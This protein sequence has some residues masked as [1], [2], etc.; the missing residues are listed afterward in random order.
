MIRGIAALA[1]GFG[2]LLAIGCGSNEEPVAE[3]TVEPSAVELAYPQ[4]LD[5]DLHW[6][7]LEALEAAE[8][9]VYVFVHLLDEP[10][11]VARTF[12]HGLGFAWSE[13]AEEKT[14]VR[15]YQSALAPPLRP[16]EYDLT[17]GL[18][19][20]TGRRWPLAT[21]GEEVDGR[22]YAV[23]TVT[24][25]E[26]GEHV[27]M[28]FFSPSWLPI[29]AGT[30]VQVLG[31]RWLS[32]E[33]VIRL[34]EIAEPGVL[35]LSLRIPEPEAAVEE[36]VLSE[37]A[38]QPGVRVRSN[39]GDVDVMVSGF[40][41]YEVE[42]PVRPSVPTGEEADPEAAPTL[43]SECE[44][45]VIPDFHLVSIET[46]ASKSVALDVLGWSAD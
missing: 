20:S 16:G 23:A 34:A 44:V 37:G 1:S 42:V 21:S 13:G 22:E 4:F 19:D 18:Y 6:T 28:F 45:Q 39:C 36:L 7:V 32:G 41:R 26:E 2:L 30:D 10:G 40:G 12:D 29:E 11:G 27:P 43:P 35:W 38:S 25:P 31:R 8:G 17:L 14:S 46:L 24:V 5:V 9:P 15:L 3:L 33:G